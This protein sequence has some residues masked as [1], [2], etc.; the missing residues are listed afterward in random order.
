MLNVSLTY[1][2]GLEFAEL[3]ESDM[4]ILRLNIKKRRN[5]AENRVKIQIL[6]V[7]MSEDI[8]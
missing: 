6:K 7:I 1:L 3:K 4:P 8:Q 2:R 5:S